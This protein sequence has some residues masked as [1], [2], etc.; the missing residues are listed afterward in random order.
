M[1]LFYKKHQKYLAHFNKKVKKHNIIP[2][3]HK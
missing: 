2:F 1:M 3:N